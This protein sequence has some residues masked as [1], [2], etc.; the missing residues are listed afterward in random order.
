MLFLRGKS[1]LQFPHKLLPSHCP[2]SINHSF[3]AAPP[4][5]LLPS[6]LYWYP[7]AVI[8]PQF[9]IPFFLLWNAQGALGFAFTVSYSQEKRPLY[10]VGFMRFP[11]S[12]PMLFLPCCLFFLFFFL[13]NPPYWYFPLQLFL[14]ARHKSRN[15][16]DFRP[17]GQQKRYSFG[18]TIFFPV[19]RD[20][21]FIFNPPK[22]WLTLWK[23]AGRGSLLSIPFRQ[24]PYDVLGSLIESDQP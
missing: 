9:V 10:A 6:F 3:F 18:Y 11:R 23:R 5:T 19:F 15:A 24:S 1:L 21:C 22:H 13:T 2:R 8:S 20:R 16:S 4:I 7:F 14:S 12:P 17:F